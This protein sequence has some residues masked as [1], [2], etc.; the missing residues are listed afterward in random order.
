MTTAS[1]G[2]KVVRQVMTSKVGFNLIKGHSNFHHFPQDHW[3]Y[4]FLLIVFPNV[5]SE[6]RF[7]CGLLV[8]L[9]NARYRY[10][11]KNRYKIQIKYR[12]LG[13]SEVEGTFP[14]ELK[15]PIRNLKHEQKGS[16][17]SENQNKGLDT[18]FSSSLSQTD[19]QSSSCKDKHLTHSKSTY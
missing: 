11:Y 12:D 15:D 6:N 4:F 8:V 13:H 5:F 18:F 17:T 10:R 16:P 9:V 1:Q 2:N 7:V 14:W 19:R 3:D